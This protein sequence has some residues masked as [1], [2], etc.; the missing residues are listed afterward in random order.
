[1]TKGRKPKKDAQ[2]RGGKPDSYLT[3][4]QSLEAIPV[5]GLMPPEHITANETKLECWNWIVSGG[6]KYEIEDMPLIAS[7]ATWWAIARQCEENMIVDGEICTTHKDL[8][9][10]IKKNP[11][12]GT[13]SQATNNMRQLSSELGIGPLAR[14]RMG[15]M[16]AATQSLT[17]DITDRIAAA[18]ER[19]KAL[20]K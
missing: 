6:Q 14:M 11:D 1:M 15:L 8:N 13:F 20:E 7:L 18:L 3:K 17:V 19:H 4:A 16:D 9:G 10:N 2:R 12:I 5:G